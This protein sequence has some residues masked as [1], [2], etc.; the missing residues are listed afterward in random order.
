MSLEYRQGNIINA[1]KKGE[2]NFLMHQVNCVGEMG[3]G[4]ARSIAHHFP[5]T[6]KEL[7]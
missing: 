5:N 3:A 6:E 7:S 2:I 1:F 4:I